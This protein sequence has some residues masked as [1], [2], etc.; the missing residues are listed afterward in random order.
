MHAM[1]HFQ[2]TPIVCMPQWLQVVPSY[3]LRRWSPISHS[4]KSPLFHDLCFLLP[5]S[6]HLPDI[7][8]LALYVHTMYSMTLIIFLLII[9]LHTCLAVD[10]CIFTVSAIPSK[11]M[12]SVGTIYQ[13]LLTPST[14]NIIQV[15][16]P[17]STTMS[18]SRIST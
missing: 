2:R 7:V 13:T 11:C 1:Y 12:V 14:P 15:D 18:R 4:H 10:R 5:V 8:V 6:N 3:W 17:S 9:F 16:W